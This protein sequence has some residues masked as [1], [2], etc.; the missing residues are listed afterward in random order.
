MKR[1]LGV[2][3]GLGGL[4]SGCLLETDNA[5][6]ELHSGMVFIGAGQFGMGCDVTADSNCEA[7]E[8][9]FRQVTLEAYWIDDVEVDQAV[10]QE[11]ILAGGCSAPATE[12]DNCAWN[13]IGR[14]DFPV[15]CV[16]NTQARDYCV[17][18][19]KRLPTEAEWERAARGANAALYPWGNEP[20]TCDLA[21]S[22]ECGQHLAKVRS[23]PA[24]ATPDG[25]FE[26]AGNAG[27]WVNDWYADD[28]YGRAPEANPLGP[29]F[30]EQRVIR[31][32][33]MYQGA[34]EIRASNRQ[35]LEPT[36]YRWS[37]GFRCASSSD[38]R[39]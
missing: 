4:W 5:V 31:G 26:M 35:A 37:V 11:C 9:P 33:N 39:P 36:A 34:V 24:G 1:I 12:Y 27:E 32:G 7:D 8:Q 29:S 14:S 30:G 3:A 23:L 22:G 2:V 20:P 28:Y 6:D 19:Y 16:T 25:I 21:N 17:W 38:A 15:V 13:P 10:Y 18:R